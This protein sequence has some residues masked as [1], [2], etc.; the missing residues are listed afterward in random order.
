VPLVQATGNDRKLQDKLK[1]SGAIPRHVAVI[2]DGNGRWASV[3]GK[4]RFEGHVAGV[5]SVK[6]VVQA[7][8]E[9]NIPVLSLFAFSSE[10]W[11]RPAEEVDFLMSLLSETLRK[12]VTELHA[13][14]IRLCFSGDR[15]PLADSLKAEMQNAETLTS[16]NTTLTLNIM[17]NY[18]GQWDITQALQALAHKVKEGQLLP[19]EIRPEHIA[20]HLSTAEIGPPDLFI[21]TSGELRI[22]NFYLWQL[23]YT[24]LYF[25][26]ALWPDFRAKDL[27][28]ALTA[29]AQ[30]DR[31][32]GKLSDVS[33]ERAEHV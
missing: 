21:R 6:A 13:K 17:L 22:S 11:S 33:T 18:G 1:D 10:N 7:C 2:M 24:E 12:E 23:A 31:R 15:A 8:L 3:R 30:R 32:F 20:E 9:K 25:T 26:K 19:E 4:P 27:E 16:A 5:Q 29:F 28:L 14:N